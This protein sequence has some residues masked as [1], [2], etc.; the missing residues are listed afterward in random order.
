LDYYLKYPS[1]VASVVLVSS[2]PEG[3]EF[4]YYQNSTESTKEQ[5]ASYTTT[6]LAQRRGLT[7]I[8]LGLA[9]PWG[10]SPMFFPLSRPARSYMYFPSS[11][12]AGELYAQPW[13]SNFWIGQTES[14][15]RIMETH[16]DS[17]YTDSSNVVANMTVKVGHILCAP[18]T[19]EEICAKYS[20]DQGTSCSQYIRQERYYF[21]KVLE[22]TYRLNPNSKLI[23]ETRSIDDGSQSWKCSDYILESPFIG[24]QFNSILT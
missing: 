24:E 12:S 21:E 4:M 11:T 2:F 1:K 15:R 20:W 14:L 16:P 6:T 10:L 22:M 8:L 18:L 5:T 7:A 13:K 23:L 3:I 17:L 9:I 19:D